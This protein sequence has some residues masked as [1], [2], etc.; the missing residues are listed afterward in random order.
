MKL[1]A[2][3]ILGTVTLAIAQYE[4]TICFDCNTCKK[5]CNDVQ[6]CDSDCLVG[7][8]NVLCELENENCAKVFGCDVP[9]VAITIYPAAN[10][11]ESQTA[12]KSQT[13]QTRKNCCYKLTGIYDNTLSGLKN[14]GACVKLYGNSDCTGDS[15]IVD[16]T[17][18][19]ECLKWI[20]C[21]S[22]LKAGGIGFNDKTSS[23]KLC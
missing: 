1:Q 9:P 21:L 14:N 22:R 23:F 17:W 2:I 8:R 19:A 15:V 3:L 10:Y 5:K 20:D 12:W 13:I 16:S 6:N 11:D 18:S 7:M 4:E